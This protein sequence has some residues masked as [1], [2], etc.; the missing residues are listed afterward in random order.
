[1]CSNIYRTDSSLVIPTLWCE[2][3]G[4]QII[5]S[6]GLFV[7]S[8]SGRENEERE[9]G[10]MHRRLTRHKLSPFGATRHYAALQNPSH[11]LIHTHANTHRLDSVCPWGLDLFAWN[12]EPGVHRDGFSEE[13]VVRCIFI[14]IR[15]QQKLSVFL[16]MWHFDVMFV[17]EPRKGNTL[18]TAG[19]GGWRGWHVQKFHRFHRISV[20]GQKRRGDVTG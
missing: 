8:V 3:G 9:S 12:N 2:S 19:L 16:T 14:L 15:I 1:M 20:S 11:L 10:E 5:F 4:R 17:F 6:Q 18:V 13:T 7:R